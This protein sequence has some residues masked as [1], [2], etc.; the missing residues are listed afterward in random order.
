[1]S[2]QV[3]AF[4]SDDDDDDVCDHGR[5]KPRERETF[6]SPLFGV[7][8]QYSPPNTVP[9]FNPWAC[10]YEGHALSEVPGERRIARILIRAK[11]S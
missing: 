5:K 4:N 7:S 11:I 1:M 10:L 2:L 3:S 8:G 6:K 9:S